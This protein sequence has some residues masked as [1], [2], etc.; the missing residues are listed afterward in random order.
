ME[1]SKLKRYV[2]AYEELGDGSSW[3]DK[4]EL[5]DA[6]MSDLIEEG[7]ESEMLPGRFAV[8]YRETVAA[9]FEVEASSEDEALERFEDWRLNSE[10]VYT[11]MNN[12]EWVKSSAKVV[13]AEEHDLSGIAVLTEGMWK[14]LTGEDGE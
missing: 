7:R 2:K 4:V 12:S 3:A 5:L 14:E 1:G 10:C 8:E 13:R 11:T 6:V 9:L